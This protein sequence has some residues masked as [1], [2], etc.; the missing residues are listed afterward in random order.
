M[1]DKRDRFFAISGRTHDSHSGIPSQGGREQPASVLVVVNH[2]N[3]QRHHRSGLLPFTPLSSRAVDAKNGTRR[4]PTI[5]PAFSTSPSRN[6]ESGA[7]NTAAGRTR[8]KVRSCVARSTIAGMVRLDSA[9]CNRLERRSISLT[10]VCNVHRTMG[11]Q[12]HRSAAQQFNAR[13]L[14]QWDCTFK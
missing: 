8:G 13:C 3:R 5:G 12:D 6:G 1:S 2:E 7:T 4:P 11:S 14:V 10:R 9:A